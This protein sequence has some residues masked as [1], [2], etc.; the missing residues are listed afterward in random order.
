M[1]CSFLLTKRQM[2]N[3]QKQTQVWHWIFISYTQNKTRNTA[4]F[5]NCSKANHAFTIW[6]CCQILI[7]TKISLPERTI[8]VAVV[9]FFY[10]IFWKEKSQGFISAPEYVPLTIS[11]LLCFPRVPIKFW[12]CCITSK[13]GEFGINDATSYFHIHLWAIRFCFSS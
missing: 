7:F 12:A 4:H 1:F 11:D 2:K 6:N 5:N 8:L 10:F 13:W 3:N 9:G